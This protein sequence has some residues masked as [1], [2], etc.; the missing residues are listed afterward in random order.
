MG[1]QLLRGAAQGSAAPKGCSGGSLLQLVAHQ[2]QVVQR[3]R[4]ARDARHAEQR[5]RHLVRVRIRIRVR[6]R[7]RV[8]VTVRVRVRIRIRVRLAAPDQPGHADDSFGT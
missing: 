3:Q 2:A 4:T 5:G 7:V 1:V 8:R 6:V